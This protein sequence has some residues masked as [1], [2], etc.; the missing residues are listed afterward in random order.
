MKKILLGLFLVLGIM[1]L[2]CYEANAM[3]DVG[4]LQVELTQKEREELEA[5]IPEGY[6]LLE[7]NVNGRSTPVTLY[8]QAHIQS[9]GWTNG[10]SNMSRGLGSV[11][12]AKRLEAI[13]L[14][15]SN[16]NSYFDVRYRM[17]VQTYGWLGWSWNGAV[18]GTVGQGKRAEA[19][20]IVMGQRS[21]GVVY[22]TH[23]QSIGWTGW[24]ADGA[25]SG[26]TGRGLRLEAVQAYITVKV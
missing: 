8:G 21:L 11:G 20:Q 12:Q 16:N 24:S 2:P 7:V 26:T 10:Y 23:I 19:I 1:V 22:R 4:S 25:V 18:N 5:A 6:K 15:A 3:E 17:H 9:Y 13:K 14:V